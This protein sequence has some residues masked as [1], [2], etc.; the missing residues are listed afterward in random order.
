MF[1]GVCI[2]NI[3]NYRLYNHYCIHT[4]T[5]IHTQIY[6][7]IHAHTNTHLQIHKYTHAHTCTYECAIISI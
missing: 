3:Y 5:Y 6:T 1:A 4:L 2:P 7:Y